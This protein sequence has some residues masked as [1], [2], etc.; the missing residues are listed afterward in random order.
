M[1]QKK[2]TEL[3]SQSFFNI[4]K[5]HNAKRFNTLV[6]CAKIHKHVGVKMRFLTTFLMLILRQST[7]FLP[8]NSVRLSRNLSRVHTALK[9]WGYG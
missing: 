7:N 9:N 4:T 2:S 6:Q 5:S 3:G 1:L 8:V